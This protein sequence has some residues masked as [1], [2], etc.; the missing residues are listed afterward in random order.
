MDL[1]ILQSK[2]FFNLPDSALRQISLVFILSDDI[3][4]SFLDRKALT[5]KDTAKHS[6]CQ[7]QKK[8]GNKR[9][10][11]EQQAEARE[12]NGHDERKHIKE[13]IRNIL[14]NRYQTSM[15]II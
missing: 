11:K 3:V 12:Q 5:D 10:L 9:N 7:Q 14:C 6:S 15:R 1:M 2:Y 4:F 8:G 13:D